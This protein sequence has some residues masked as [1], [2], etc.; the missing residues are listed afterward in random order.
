MFFHDLKLFSGFSKSLLVALVACFA[1]VGCDLV[2]N[3]LKFDR[4]KDLE[5][6]DFRDGMAERDLEIDQVSDVAPTSIPPLRP[7]VAKSSEVMKQMP[8]VSVS[9]NDTVPLR[10]LLFDLANQTNYDLELDP[11]I[12]GSIIFTARSRPLDEVIERISDIAGL[13][14]RFK[15]DVLRVERDTPYNKTYKIDYLSYIRTNEGAVRTD[16]AVVSGDGADTGSSFEATS[17]SEADFWGELNTNLSQILGVRRSNVASAQTPSLS[18]ESDDDGEAVLSVGSVSGAG[19]S[20]DGQSG[21]AA[22]FAVNRQ[23]GLVSVFA[24]ERQHNEVGEYLS[25]LR[26]ASTAQVLIE[27]KILEVTLNDEFSTGVDWNYVSSLTGESYS[28]GMFS[29]QAQSYFNSTM[30]AAPAAGTVIAD[31]SNFVVGATGMDLNAVVQA[32]SGFGSVRAL[33]SPRLTV[34]NNQSAVL[35]VATNEVFFELDINVT[36]TDTQTSTDVESEIRNVPE[37]VLVNVQPS[38]NLDTGTIAMA[39]RPT[40]T[41]ITSRVAD[42]AVAFVAANNNVTGIESLVPVLNVQE[43]DS[44]IQVNSGQPVIM[45]GLLQDKSA[46]TEQGLPVV[47]EVPVLGNLFKKHY[48]LTAK[49]EL[50]IFLKATILENPGDSVHATDRDLYRKFSGD[51]R[52]LKF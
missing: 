52:P 42:P 47:S 25:E 38:I 7:Y 36:T 39:V 22:V 15:N 17:S 9:V 21:D 35:N 29:D 2:D 10:D 43:I 13:R 4:S 20:S 12:E 18:S 45:G 30:N 11:N 26:R 6:Q 24:T 5:F 46:T 23:A 31:T 19:S 3:Q 1:L 27:A 34:L 33:A 50:V 48:D 32:V 41:Q 49:T 28:I 37:G 16:I 14:Y 51:R 8:L 44:V 40:I